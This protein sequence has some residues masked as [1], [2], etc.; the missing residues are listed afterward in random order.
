[1]YQ[2]LNSAECLVTSII[3]NFLLTVV[4]ERSFPILNSITHRNMAVQGS[5]SYYIEKIH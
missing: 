4:L 2:S 1:M 3:L 5:L